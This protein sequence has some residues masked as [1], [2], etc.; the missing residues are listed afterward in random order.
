MAK[1]Y[2]VNGM[3]K[4]IN[5]MM[6]FTAGRGWG[7][8]ELLTTVGARSGKQRQVPVSPIAVDGVEYLV[9]PYGEVAWVGNARASSS[10]TLRKGKNTRRCTLVEVT[11]EAAEVLKAYWDK[12]PFVHQYMDV[13]ESPTV[14]DFANT[15]SAFPVF[16]VETG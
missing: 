1:A 9:A 10:V 6:T 7:H 15:G 2:E 3:V 14:D 11:G 13:P 8:Q 5:M 12:E 16:R 4:A